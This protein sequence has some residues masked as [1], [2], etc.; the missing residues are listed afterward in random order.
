[1][2]DPHRKVPFAAGHREMS[3]AETMC[4]IDVYLFP[5]IP[6]PV[7]RIGFLPPAPAGRGRSALAGRA[8]RPIFRR[9]SVERAS[10]AQPGIAGADGHA[11]RCARSHIN[12]LA[13]IITLPPVAGLERRRFAV[14]MPKRYIAS[15][16]LL[17]GRRH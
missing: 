1:M 8:S 16:V 11:G 9:A 12:H 5:G 14:T 2:R 4:D 10:P 17:F 15:A 7:D 6:I 13:E 3:T